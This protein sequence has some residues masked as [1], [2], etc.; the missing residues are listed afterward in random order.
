MFQSIT[1]VPAYGRDYR[2][3]AAV[4]ADW[5]AGKDFQDAVTG[6]YLSIRDNVPEVWVRYAER[7]KVVRVK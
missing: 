5:N 1:A 2:S 6:Q 7:T 4:L 3:I